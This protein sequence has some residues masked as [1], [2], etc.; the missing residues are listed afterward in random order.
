MGRAS[1]HKPAGLAS[2]LTPEEEKEMGNLEQKVKDY[3]Y[4]NGI[5]GGTVHHDRLEQL[6]RKAGLVSQPTSVKEEDNDDTTS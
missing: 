3:A 4:R 5:M 6:R 1:Q 2:G